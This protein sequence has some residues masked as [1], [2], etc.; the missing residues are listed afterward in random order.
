MLKRNTNRKHFVACDAGT[1]ECPSDVP[2]ERKA[3]LRLKVVVDDR[4][5]AS[6][7]EGISQPPTVVSEIYDRVW[8]T[9]TPLLN[10]ASNNRGDDRCL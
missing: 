8:P 6:G 4:D 10:K 9:M 3:T 1:A 2:T 7:R 5:K